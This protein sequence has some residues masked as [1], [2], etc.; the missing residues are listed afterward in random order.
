MEL[1]A[2]I[3]LVLRLD[4]SEIPIL[5]PFGLVPERIFHERIVGELWGTGGLIRRMIAARRFVG[6]A[7]ATLL[8]MGS[9]GALP[10]AGFARNW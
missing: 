3:H 1:G 10:G 4:I 6:S 9:G 2:E 8:D 7:T 5:E